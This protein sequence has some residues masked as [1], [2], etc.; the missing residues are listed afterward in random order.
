MNLHLV[1]CAEDE[2]RRLEGIYGGYRRSAGKQS[3]WS[4]GNPGNAA[5]RA[6]L[7]GMAFSLAGRELIGAE[8][9]L[10]VGCGS[11]W[12][13]ECLAADARVS[14]RLGGVELLPERAASARGRVP[15]A[16]IAQADARELP[17]DT[18]SFEVVTL[19]TVLSSL[20][21]VADAERTLREARRVLRPG[22]V[23]LIW[24]PRVRNPFNRNTVL[25][26]RPLLERALTGT[27]VEARTLTVLPP[28]AR[29]L[30]KHTPRLYPRLSRIGVVHTHRLVRASVGHERNAGSPG[31]VPLASERSSGDP[32]ASASPRE[33]PRASG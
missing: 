11:G 20:S 21:G 19:F 24:E 26:D 4:A 29:R 33:R 25:I 23:L 8:A 18:G 14:A 3:D 22:G 1:A 16:A 30:G 17:F 32:H 2:Q 28:L 13:L 5:I 12:W 31:N 9:I 7:V 10:D 15:R 27:R 6:E